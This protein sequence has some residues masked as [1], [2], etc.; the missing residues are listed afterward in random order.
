MMK[1]SGRPDSVMYIYTHMYSVYIGWAGT[2]RNG[3]PSRLVLLIEDRPTEL[4]CKCVLHERTHQHWEQYV[5]QVNKHCS[6]SKANRH[7]Y[8]HKRSIDVW[9]L[10][11]VYSWSQ[12]RPVGRCKHNLHVHIKDGEVHVL[13]CCHFFLTLHVPFLNPTPWAYSLSFSSHSLP[14]SH[15]L[16]PSLPPS[17]AYFYT[18]DDG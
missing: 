4:S 17:L 15:P 13:F 9:L 6:R 7:R 12:Q 10:S 18:H 14:S 3:I 8:K 2:A 16:S 5:G 11:H 1:N